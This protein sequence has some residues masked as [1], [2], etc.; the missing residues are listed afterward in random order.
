MKNTKLPIAKGWYSWEEN[1]NKK[2]LSL[3]SI[4]EIP[5]FI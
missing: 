3:F 1:K 5:S 2:T 4:Y